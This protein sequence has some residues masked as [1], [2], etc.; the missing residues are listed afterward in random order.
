CRLAGRRLEGFFIMCGIGGWLG[1]LPDH[2]GLAKRMVQALQH[3]GP[4]AHGIRSWSKATLV[5]TR[6]SIIDLSLAGAQP[7]TNEDGTVWTVFNGEIY[8]HREL[9]HDLETRGHVFKGHSDTEVLPHLYEEE[10]LTFVAK[11]RGM[12]ALAI[13]DTRTYTL[14]LARDRF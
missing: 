4:D 6:L 2:E 3:R 8:N 11:L 12:F 9:R 13:Y 14:I 10:G 7:M 1:T 5:H